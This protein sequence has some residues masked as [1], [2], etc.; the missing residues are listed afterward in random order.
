MRKESIERFGEKHPLV[1]KI[2]KIQEKMQNIAKTPR[3][4]EWGKKV[5][6]DMKNNEKEIT[7][8]GKHC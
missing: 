2:K 6:K 7:V 3:W 1:K 5:H 8:K 4:I